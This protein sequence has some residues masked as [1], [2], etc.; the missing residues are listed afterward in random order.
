MAWA[1]RFT[2]YN[3]LKGDLQHLQMLTFRD[4][5]KDKDSVST[6]REVKLSKSLFLQFII[7]IDVKSG[8]TKQIMPGPSGDLGEWQTLDVNVTL[9]F[10][11]GDIDLLGLPFLNFTLE[12]RHYLYNVT[13]L[14]VWS[15]LR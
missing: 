12:P 5:F 9:G 4:L 15:F 7:E 6:K 10:A 2:G 14:G 8:I 11:S 1:A 3:N 13:H